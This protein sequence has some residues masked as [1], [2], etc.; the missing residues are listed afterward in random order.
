MNGKMSLLN[1]SGGPGVHSSVK[2][3][4]DVELVRRT[5]GGDAEAFSALVRR[6][7]NSA[8]MVALSEL[9]D[10]RDAEDAAQ[11]S[12]IQALKRLE[13]CRDPSK[14]GAWVRMIAR[15]RAR[16]LGRSRRVR[17]TEPL[18]VVC[19]AADRTDPSRDMERQE[20]RAHLERA[21]GTLKPV[22]RQVIVLHDL[23]G[24]KHG[25]I[26]L[27]LGIPEGTV[28]SHLH[29]ARRALRELLG[30]LYRSG[31]SDERTH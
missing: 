4:D 18:E 1:E 14:F 9:G 22:Q 23:E 17:Q 21:L 13:E 31:E 24:M 10:T 12:F 15:N 8:Y 19:E 20:L 5:L 11:D 26:A 7:M 3:D 2:Q 6:H 28:R 29:F 25:E 30:G 16:S 27:D